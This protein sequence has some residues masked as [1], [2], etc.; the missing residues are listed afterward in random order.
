M[1]NLSLHELMPTVVAKPSPATPVAQEE[2]SWRN[3]SAAKPLQVSET[4]WA[5]RQRARRSSQLEG[6]VAGVSDEEIVR[7]M[8]SILNKLTVEKSK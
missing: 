6:E 5:G 4:S 1:I 3:V 8:K 2:K 7:S